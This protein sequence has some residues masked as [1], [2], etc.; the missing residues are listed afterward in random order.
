V[1]P[2]TVPEPHGPAALYLAADFA[3]VSAA[4][5]R[6]GWWT[7]AEAY[8]RAL[9]EAPRFADARRAQWVLGQVDLMLGFL[10]EAAAAFQAV[11]LESHDPLA[12]EARI[13]LAGALRAQGRLAQARRVLEPALA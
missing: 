8:E 1:P 7:A 4:R 5:G 12:L 9:H 2:E 13:A 11:G 3:F 10:P 6:T